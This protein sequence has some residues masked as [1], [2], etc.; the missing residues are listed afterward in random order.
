M[1]EATHSEGIRALLDW[2]NQRKP[3]SIDLVGDYAGQELFLVE[4]DSLLL[5]CFSNSKLDFGY[6]LQVLHATYAVEHYLQNLVRRKCNF[7]LTFVEEHRELCIPVDAPAEHREKYLLAR[8]AII[9]HLHQFLPETHPSLQLLLFASIRGAEFERY[10]SSTGV[11]FVVCHDGARPARA[12]A[13]DA[14]RSHHQ[15]TGPVHELEKLAFRGM[16]WWFIHH[17][18]NVALV[19]GLEWRDSKVITMIV[20]GTRDAPITP[21]L[22]DQGYDEAQG[23][24]SSRSIAPTGII[25]ILGQLHLSDSAAEKQPNGTVAN[26]HVHEPE[27]A[28]VPELNG[29]LDRIAT[30]LGSDHALLTERVCLT[31]VTLAQILS[32]EPGAVSLAAVVLLQLVLTSHVP[33]SS[34][35]VEA[36]VVSSEHGGEPDL[37]LF[38]RRFVTVSGILMSSSAWEQA[39]ERRVLPCDV[40]DLID[41]RLLKMVWYTGN[42]RVVA[43]QLPTPIRED[44]HTLADTLG[45]ICGLPLRVDEASGNTHLLRPW[46][47]DRRPT[48][49]PHMSVL[50]F[51]NPVFDEHLARIKLATDSS[52]AENPGVPAKI[53]R[54][55]T[56]WHNAKRPL[57]KKK[58]LPPGVAEKTQKRA[59]RSNQFYMAEMSAYAASLTNSAG[60][61][62]EPEIITVARGKK[63]QQSSAKDRKED[64]K[65]TSNGPKGGPNAGKKSILADIAAQRESKDSETAGRLFNRVWLNARQLLD[66]AAD[67]RSRYLKTEK[68]LE[69]LPDSKRVVLEAEIRVYMLQALV[70]IWVQACKE[71]K[72]AE[73]YG[74]AALLWDSLR[75]LVLLKDGLTPAIAAYVEKISSL[76]QLPVPKPATI[77]TAR[78]PSFKFTI[79]ALTPPTGSVALPPQEFQLLHAGPY[80]DRNVDSAPD[81]RVHFEPDRWQRRV[82]DEIDANRSVFV[83]APTSAG[84][85]F[86]SFYAME[87]ILRADD[88]GVLVYVAPTKALVNQ[89]AAE[90]QG[91]FKKN[92]EHG[93]KSVWAI[94]TRDHK[95]NNP[96]GCQILVTVPHV[97]QIMLLAPINAT[98]WSTRVKR[99]IFDEIHEIGQAED[100]VVWEQLL[101]LAP[102]P[103]IALSATVGNPEQFSSWME[104][105]Q[106]SLNYDLTMITHASR[107]SDLR[108]FTYIPPTRFVF[109][110]LPDRSAFTRLGLDDTP[111]F[112]F[113][114][115]ISSLVN[116]SRGMPDDLTLE[117]RDCLSLWKAMVKHQREGYGVPEALDPAKALPH[118]IKKVEVTNW[119]KQLKAL[120]RVWM[121]DPK[122]PFEEIRATLTT[123]KAIPEDLLISRGTATDVAEGEAERLDPSNLEAT[124]LPMLARLHARDALPAILFN[125]DRTRCE[126]VCQAL[127]SQLKSSEEQWKAT[128]PKWKAMVKGWE[129]W[130]KAN[131]KMKFKKPAK[132]SSKKGGADAEGGVSKA[133]QAKDNAS[134]EQN[135]Y[136]SFNPDA[137]SDLFSF[138][139]KRKLQTSELSQYF[140]QL[141]RKGVWPWLLEALTR[142]IGVHHAGM[143]RKYRQVVE[144][145]FRKGYLRVVI[146]TGTL[147]LGINMPCA[148]VV[149]SGDSLFLTALNFRQ[150][151]GRAGRRGFDLLGNVVFQGITHEKVCRLLSSRLPDLNGHFPITTTLVLRLFM[152]LRESDNS[153]FATRSINSLLSQPRL[154]LGGESFRDQVLHHLRFSIEYL[155]RQGLLSAKGTPQNFAGCVTHLYYTE[156]S[157]FAFHALL[158]EGYFHD[159]CAGFDANEANEARV[160]ETLMIVMSHLFGRRPCRQADQEYLALVKQSSSVVFLPELP[161]KAA[162]VLRKHNRETLECFSTY[163]K[164]FADEHLKEEERELPLTGHRVGGKMKRG[165]HEAF[166]SLPATTTRSAF[167]ALSGH[168]DVFDSVSDLCDTARQGIF[169]EK[170]IIPHLDVY[171]DEASAPLNAYLYDFYK[172]GDVTQLSKANGIGRGD[173]WFVLND[174][175]LVLATIIASLQVFMKLSAGTDLDMLDVIGDGD[176]AENAQDDAIAEADEKSS[177]SSVATTTSLAY[178][179]SNTSVASTKKSNTTS[180]GTG[181]RAKVVDDWETAASLEAKEDDAQSARNS[182]RA[183]ASA[184][185]NK[186]TLG[187]DG[188]EIWTGTD[189]RGLLQVLKAFQKLRAEF[190]VKFKKM[191]A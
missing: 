174:F 129:T 105:T 108:K 189:E 99:I 111:G 11:Y 10:L 56:H 78:E 159:L 57:E 124:T 123:P 169:L 92:Y 51:S 141:E 83:V 74:T 46:V 2:Y 72:R 7:H 26:G 87:Q 183:E 48:P 39:T 113:V 82:L 176:V 91:R 88:N 38:L 60:K 59:L 80:M 3:R 157:S 86:I 44:F 179:S 181:R 177:V 79:P 100:G 70:E 68:Y 107:Y 165:D 71:G 175:S 145:L 81:P 21:E 19:N 156:N 37:T 27:T 110:G 36:V 132:T 185:S 49:T 158:K 53:H 28:G 134:E 144:I 6:G 116:T 167:V 50:P 22:L 102:C 137:P 32:D 52:S 173:V 93:G 58:Q 112:S 139:D 178:A 180:T 54:E 98:T 131:E 4:G 115:P 65:A 125:Y 120:I 151:A 109:K 150:A 34:R 122:S 138:A 30:S 164:T 130:K 101:L 146:A 171:P 155:R 24:L 182:S 40:A 187:L 103:I 76:L 188:E 127:L 73:G 55:V 62:L 43:D 94:H 61:S 191:W 18:Y 67:P 166:S 29:L 89:I 143:N 128:S 161:S 95:V 160:L 69:E 186:H 104:S 35:R 162:T 63:A 9:R 170:A 142:G 77:G 117:A 163:V 126:N 190:D 41:G 23:A 154:Y 152:L 85:T 64:K 172:H 66:G 1:D 14:D 75:N 12:M 20:E 5:E 184:R 8:A 147:A 97:L 148:T 140:W 17:G 31:I 13:A 149:F 153:A 121:A 106:K 135:P 42:G 45:M 133:D 119:E 15:S 16:I 114:H 96:L 25:E 168:G 84:K 90:I 118:I 33:L 47:S 136:E